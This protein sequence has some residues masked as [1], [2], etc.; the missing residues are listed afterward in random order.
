LFHIKSFFK[1]SLK[2]K[3][4]Y[5]GELSYFSVKIDYSF[6]FI[7]HFGGELIYLFVTTNTSSDIW[8]SRLLCIKSFTIQKKN[9]NRI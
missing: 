9:W 7:H 4:Y 6:I 3:K 1:F 2:K 8:C 5:G